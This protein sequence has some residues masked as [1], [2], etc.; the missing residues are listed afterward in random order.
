MTQ[1][2]LVILAPAMR[3]G[4]SVGAV[5]WRHA[6]ELA[7]TRK[8]YVI[9]RDVPAQSVPGVHPILVQPRS[10]TWLRRFGHVPGELSFVRAVR[11]QLLAL[12][13]RER[14]GAVWCHG[15]ALAALVAAPLKERL[16]FTAVMTT[17][18]D[19]FDRPP[20]TYP[21]DLTWFYRRVT[22]AAYR[23]SDLVHVLSPYMGECAVRG[24]AARSK[25]RFIPNGI[26]PSDLGCSNVALRKADSFMPAGELRL[27]YVGSLWNVKGVDVLL[28][29][30]A[31]LKARPHAPAVRLEVAGDGPERAALHA[32]ASQLGLENS[33][34]FHG[35]VPR[36]AVANLYAHADILCIPSLSEALPTVA[37]EAML[38][39]LPVVG[40]DTGGIPELVEAGVT[41]LLA[42][43]GDASA[44]AACLAQAAASPGKLAAFGAAG[45]SRVRSQF[46]W[47]RVG[48]ALRA[49][50]ADACAG[51]GHEAA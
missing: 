46:S 38:M 42:T 15:H 43:P 21:G 34:R 48:D 28:R 22:P 39:G 40:S 49:L 17:H 24:G 14:V 16:G 7:R 32:L 12:C 29:A 1:P 20:G 47:D 10:W 8:V 23:Q 35:N 27:L 2:A 9:T 13:A 45:A 37:L 41:G 31:E 5:A 11:A 25:V 18:G 3:N 30:L 6:A 44:L 36:A 33:V 50:A 4:G 51:A 19:I 26:D